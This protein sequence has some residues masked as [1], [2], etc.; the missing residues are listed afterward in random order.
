MA[1]LPFAQNEAA[2]FVS[3]AKAPE[4]LAAGKPVVATPIR[5]VVNPHADLGLV[6]IADGVDSF[7]AVVDAELRR[8]GNATW[9]AA[10]D[11]HLAQQSWDCT[12][13]RMHALM[14]PLLRKGGEVVP[15]SYPRG[16]FG[17][18]DPV[19]SEPRVRTPLV[20]GAG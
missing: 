4:Y 11:Q 10:V 2:R 13:M 7:V 19:S 8:G 15:V 17:A 20:S 3:P 1:I 9:L 12:A 18:I 6:T 16:R 14:Q 5:D